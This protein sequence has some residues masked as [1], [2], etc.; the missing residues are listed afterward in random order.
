LSPA[1]LM[2][3]REERVLIAG[4]G[5]G[6]LATAI[7]LG[8]RGIETEILE[9][10]GAREHTLTEARRYRDLALAHVDRLPCIDDRKADLAELV[11]SVIAA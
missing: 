7:A 3:R 9:R 11:R 5:I 10:S 2:P 4:G 8:R 6:G 1:W